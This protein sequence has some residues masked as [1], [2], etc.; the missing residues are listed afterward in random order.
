MR[1][2]TKLGAGLI[3]AGTGTAVAAVD[4]AD[5]GAA[6]LAVVSGLLSGACTALGATALI[7]GWTSHR[8]ARE[9][10]EV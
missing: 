4:A 10:S 5:H 7:I 2:T 6:S 1:K 9:D 3:V 8:P